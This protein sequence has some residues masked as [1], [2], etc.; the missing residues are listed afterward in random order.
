MEADRRRH[1]HRHKIYFCPKPYKTITKTYRMQEKKKKRQGSIEQPY[2]LP[3]KML[4][5]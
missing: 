2:G 5:N 4:S 1:R 3:V